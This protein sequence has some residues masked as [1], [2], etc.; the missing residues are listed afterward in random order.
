MG[1]QN[2]ATAEVEPQQGASIT[3]HAPADLALEELSGRNRW[4]SEN[5][6]NSV[7]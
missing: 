7:P 1:G 6:P 2:L 3:Q 5:R 4:E